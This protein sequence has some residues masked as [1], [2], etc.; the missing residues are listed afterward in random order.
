M[1]LVSLDLSS[2]CI[3]EGTFFTLI[4]ALGA[5]QV[6]LSRLDLS[7]NSFFRDT[8]LS[9]LLDYLENKTMEILDSKCKHAKT[10]PIV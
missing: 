8:S 3:T 10:L 4:S 9:E 6:R 2:R 1:P 5:S 7:F